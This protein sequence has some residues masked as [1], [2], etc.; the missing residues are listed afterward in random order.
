[1]QIY[2]TATRTFFNNS[3]ELPD[4][5]SVKDL[6]TIAWKVAVPIVENHIKHSSLAGVKNGTGQASTICCNKQVKAPGTC[7]QTQADC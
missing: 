6:S 5:Y 3:Y 4:E 2:I 7:V 1:M